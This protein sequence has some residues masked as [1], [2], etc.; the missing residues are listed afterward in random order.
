MQLPVVISFFILLLLP[1]NSGFAQNSRFIGLPII[2]N[3][4]PALYGFHS[5][6]WGAVQ[7]SRGLIYFANS[8]GILEYDGVKWRL[9]R[10]PNGE[11]CRVL[12]HAPDGIVYVAGFNEI[13]YIAY[14]KTGEAEYTSLKS[15]MTG[16]KKDFL[17][18]WSISAANGKVYFSTYEEIFIWDGNTVNTFNSKR[19]ISSLVHINGKLVVAFSD[20]NPEYFDGKKF[21]PFISNNLHENT[22]RTILCQ[23]EDGNLLLFTKKGA[24]FEIIN[25]KIIK[26]I[27]DIPMLN[28]GGSIYDAKLL[29]NGLIALA[30][31]T[32][33]VIIIDD[34]GTIIQSLNEDTGLG[35][36]VAYSIY[37][38]RQNNL[39]ITLEEGLAK[40]NINSPISIFDK[41]F[42]LFGALADISV[43]NNKLFV[44][45]TFGIFSADFFSTTSEHVFK[46]LNINLDESWSFFHHKEKFY[47]TSSTGL[48][49]IEDNGETRL[50]DKYCFMALS[51]RDSSD[52]VL[53]A[54]DDG[55]TVIRLDESGSN[56][57][58][59]IQVEG[60]SGEVRNITE[61]AKGDF[62]IEI[63]PHTL[64]RVKFN[65]GYFNKPEVTK[66]KY[67]SA[68]PGNAIAT[69]NHQGVPLIVTTS[70]LL[71]F[72]PE[73][74]IFTPLNSN[75]KIRAR[76]PFSSP[77]LCNTSSDNI[78]LFLDGGLFSIKI[79]PDNDSC[80]VSRIGRI[81]SYNVYKIY[82]DK[83]IDEN[84]LW[85]ATSTGLL[86][87]DLTKRETQDTKKTFVRSVTAGDSVW[88]SGVST[89]KELL[90][91]SPGSSIT[92]SFSALSFE[93]ES[94]VLYQ[95]YMDG[96]DTSWQP[97]NK[98][99]FREFASLS[100]GNYKFRVRSI[101]P[102][103]IVT[104]EEVFHLKIRNYWYAN[105]YAYALYLLILLAVVTFIIKT[106]TSLLVLERDRLE[107]IVNERTGKL[108]ALNNELSLKNQQLLNTNLQLEQF[109]KEKS[110]YLGIVAHDLKNPLAGV[111]GFAEILGDEVDQLRV[112]EIARYAENIRISSTSMLDIINKL[113]D[114]DRMEQGKLELVLHDFD[115]TPL[116]Q[117]T[118]ESNL[119]LSKRKSIT[120]LFDP[121]DETVYIY[122]DRNLIYQII[123]NLVSNA[124]KYSYSNSTVFVRCGFEQADTIFLEVEDHGVGIPADEINLLFKKF[125]KLSSRPTAG[126]S[127][128]GLGLSIVYMLCKLLGGKIICSSKPG[129]G[130]TFKVTLPK[131]NGYLI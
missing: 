51:P 14:N 30:T 29:S 81:M 57:V 54:S 12:F 97:S 5:Q 2:Y 92:I 78:I 118:I 85:L 20:G 98:N 42:K 96:I 22:E 76:E 52:I 19:S 93:D 40:I 68:G 90:K 67:E 87:Y 88:F 31:V 34:K 4:S 23:K 58:Q 127:S 53:L 33:G 10:L 114:I 89:G 128:T 60:I 1:L 37:E 55:L 70:G 108:L 129:F 39:W 82:A 25:G 123:D 72:N 77:L 3:Y 121:P 117:E 63:S 41:R 79:F 109:D 83:S 26:I 84:T 65:N 116:I 7:D 56:V 101:L 122:S 105:N 104:P 24:M 100:P 75:L 99:P 71:K 46:R 49:K 8:D 131:R 80:H 18:V 27:D 15:K 119:P 48:Y 110:E 17:D 28:D 103:G 74:N 44:S 107:E 11:T 61:L 95:T 120:I 113:L 36:N 66:S 73:N 21:T 59:S 102:S 69:L 16:R 35:N 111:L 43:F 115:I 47:I 94:S 38:D 32:A 50:T 62:W 9:I 13:G 106:R 130:S 126:E 6:N 86:K 64:L 124:V 45:S 91:L 112:E 125:T